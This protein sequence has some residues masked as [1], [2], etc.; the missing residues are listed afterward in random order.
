MTRR[1]YSLLGP[2]AERAVEAGLA[3]AEWYHTDIPRKEMKAL[4]QR[5]DQPAIRDTIILFASMA[6]LAV[7]GIL[8]W[9]SLLSIPFWLA[10]GVL[11]GSAMDT[12]NTTCIRVPGRTES[13]KAVAVRG[14]ARAGR[15]KREFK[16]C[17]VSEGIF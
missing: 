13:G 3:A 1:D 17:K 5:S 16:R 12:S 7:L 8:L 10:Y 9:P 14:K 4:M 6:A 2:D 11:H 15:D